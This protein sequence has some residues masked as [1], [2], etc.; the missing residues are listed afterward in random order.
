MARGCPPVSIIH[1]WSNPVGSVM[2]KSTGGITCFLSQPKAMDFPHI[3]KSL[4][5][6]VSWCF[7]V[8]YG[9]LWCFMVFLVVHPIYSYLHPQFTLHSLQ[10]T[11]IL[12][13]LQMMSVYVLAFAQTVN[14]SCEH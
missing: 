9:V 7:M 12:D 1:H 13:L 6:G 4:F 8:F 14:P 2:V 3:P 11:Q 5:H 10:L